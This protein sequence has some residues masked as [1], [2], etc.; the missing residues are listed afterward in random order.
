MTLARAAKASQQ[1]LAKAL[2][3]LAQ[4]FPQQKQGDL[5]PLAE[6]A[7]EDGAPLLPPLLAPV[8]SGL[9]QAVQKAG[10][11][12]SI[13]PSLLGAPSRPVSSC[14][15]RRKMCSPT[16]AQDVLATQA[17]VVAKQ[18]LFYTQPNDC[19]GWDIQQ[20]SALLGGG[21]KR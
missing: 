9:V 15:P 12:T 2:F 18:L 16:K 3:S 7:T 13:R 20:S 5:D 6:E 17:K 8:R 10:E 19:A 14:Q 21:G 4:N 11:S 1:A